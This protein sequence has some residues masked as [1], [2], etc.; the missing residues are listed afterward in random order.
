M[1]NLQINYNPNGD[2]VEIINPTRDRT[3]LLKNFVV[4][5][6]FIY[7]NWEEALNAKEV[8]VAG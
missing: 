4:L 8:Y 5:N 7:P 3:H 6:G 2:R 1:E